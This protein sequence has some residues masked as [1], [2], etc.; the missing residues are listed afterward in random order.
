MQSKTAQL[1]ALVENQK[2][3]NTWS[4]TPPTEQ[5]FYWHWSGSVQTFTK[6]KQG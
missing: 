2:T 4:E 5:G 6:F 1:L 3:D